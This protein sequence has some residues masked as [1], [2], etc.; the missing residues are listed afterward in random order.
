MQEGQEAFKAQQDHIFTDLHVDVRRHRSLLEHNKSNIKYTEN[1]IPTIT[2]SLLETYFAGSH[3]CT[4]ASR[5]AGVSLAKS[6]QSLP[7]EDDFSF[8]IF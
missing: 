2:I 3:A 4:M 7:F 1:R 5:Q 6:D 8:R